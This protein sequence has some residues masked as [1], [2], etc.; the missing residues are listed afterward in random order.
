MPFNCEDLTLL[1]SVQPDDS[2]ALY[3]IILLFCSYPI[4]LQ[5]IGIA[6]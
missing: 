3:Q 2:V 5:V 4:L 6:V 1:I